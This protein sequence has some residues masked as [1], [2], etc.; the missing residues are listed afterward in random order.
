M[1]KETIAI[2]IPCKNEADSI[3]DT[4]RACM[5]ALPN[6]RIIVGDNC[7]TDGTADRA[8]EAG[9]EVI[10]CPIPGKG[11]ALRTLL[12][13]VNA[14]IYG[15]IDGDNT[16]D[17]K[18]FIP[19]IKDVQNNPHCVATGI[20]QH[21]DPTAFPRGHQL[22]NWGLN[23]LAALLFG[24]N[25]GDLLSGQRVFSKEFLAHFTAY[26]NDFR[27]ETE[28]TAAA[29]RYMTLTSTPTRYIA[30]KTLGTSKLK[31]IPDGFRVLFA[32]LSYAYYIHTRK[33]FP[34]PQ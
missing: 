14:D 28:L 12:R 30:R 22:G 3:A 26:Q 16:Y 27:I 24:E 25:C 18:A 2:L 5:S 8:R 33:P 1:K 29:V 34:T 17:A 4:V 10:D 32:I 6:A 7:S 31:T 15:M 23:T 13:N 19:M 21:D 20:R 9:A 11:A